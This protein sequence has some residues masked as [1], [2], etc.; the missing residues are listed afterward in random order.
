MP[1]FNRKTDANHAYL[2]DEVFRRLCPVVIDTSKHGEHILDLII[3]TPRGSMYLVE[4]KDGSKPLSAQKLKPLQAMMLSTFPNVC[5]LV[6]N[7]TEAEEL[8]KL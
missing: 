5:K 2:R 6:R 7:Q 1:R 3:K 8:C 4:I